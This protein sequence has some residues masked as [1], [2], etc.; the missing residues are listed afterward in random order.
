MFDLY[1]I[2]INIIDKYIKIINKKLIIVFIF[3]QLTNYLKSRVDKIN[4]LSRFLL[5]Y[6]FFIM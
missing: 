4:I 1:I 3:I 2:N 6:S 5:P